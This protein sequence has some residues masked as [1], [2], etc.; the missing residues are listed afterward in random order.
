MIVRG[1]STTQIREIL[2]ELFTNVSGSVA[3]TQA[4]KQ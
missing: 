4:Q 1:T 2:S 3:Q